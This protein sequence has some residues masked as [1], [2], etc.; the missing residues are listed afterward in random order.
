MKEYSYKALTGDAQ[1]TVGTVFAENNEEA[2]SKIREM[3]LFPTK[4]VEVPE[5]CSSSV[6]YLEYLSEVVGNKLIS[7]GKTLKGEL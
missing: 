3:G 6:S 5:S 2:I 1:G 7:W 4:I